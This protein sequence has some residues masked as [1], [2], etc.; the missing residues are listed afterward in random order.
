MN[1]Q[2]YSKRELVDMCSEKDIDIQKLVDALKY[3]NMAI[4][5]VE[6]W[7]H[8]V[9]GTRLKENKKLIAAYEKK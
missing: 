8:M 7:S 6:C 3:N 4:K 2:K 5:T 1:Y 9:L